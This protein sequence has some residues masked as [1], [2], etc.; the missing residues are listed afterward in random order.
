MDNK[1]RNI[2]VFLQENNLQD[3]HHKILQNIVEENNNL[4]NDKML[5]YNSAT[6]KYRKDHLITLPYDPDSLVFLTLYTKKNIFD[7]PRI[8]YVE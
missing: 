5:I 8:Y 7:P 2:L 1:N 4:T 3:Y 6:V